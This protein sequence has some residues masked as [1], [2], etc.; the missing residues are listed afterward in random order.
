MANFRFDPYADRA[1]YIEA[2]PFAVDD[3][4]NFEINT[5]IPKSYAGALIGERG[6]SMPNLSGGGGGGGPYVDCWDHPGGVDVWVPGSVLNPMG[7][8]QTG[9]QCFSGQNILPTPAPEPMPKATIQPLPQV[10]TPAAGGRSFSPT[11]LLNPLPQIVA[12]PKAAPAPTCNPISQWVNEN[13][14]LAVGVLVL[15]FF[16]GKK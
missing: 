9:P 7:S 16:V 6:S 5:V 12:G 11:G 10:I 13:P 4:S 2:Y 1:A 15:G 3:V 14:L 8:A